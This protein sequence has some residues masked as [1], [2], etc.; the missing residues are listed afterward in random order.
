MDTAGKCDCRPETVRR[1]GTHELFFDLV[2]VFGITQVSTLLGSELTVSGFAKSALVLGLM[3]WVWSQYTWALNAVDPRRPSV[4]V[5]VIFAAGGAFFCAQSIPEV[6]GNGENWF[7]VSFAALSALGLLIYWAGL[8]GHTEHQQALHTYLP[9][10]AIAPVLVL[11]GGLLADA[12]RPLFFASALAINI[13]GAVNAGK[14]AFRIQTAHFSERYSLIVLIALGEAIVA[15][16]LGTSEVQRNPMF[17]YSAS[18]SLLLIGALYVSYF[19]WVADATEARLAQTP[20]T[21][22]A[23]LARNLYT[24]LHYPIVAGIVCIAVATERVVTNAREPLRLEG[25]VALALGVTLFLSGFILGNKITAGTWLLER[26]VALA[27]IATLCAL[28]SRVGSATLCALSAVVLGIALII[29]A[30]R[31]SLTAN[32][33]QAVTLKRVS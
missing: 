5:A 19:G 10:A 33:H 30:F 22:Q 25:R 14:S 13:A 2:F 12:L 24:F 11:A 27:V 3:W 16:G 26:I 29:E 8:A 31:R 17:I 20:A 7:G 15:V 4:T 6:F 18:A 21:Q 23:R 9:F 32:T 28:G 1:T